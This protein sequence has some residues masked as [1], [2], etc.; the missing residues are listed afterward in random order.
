MFGGLRNHFRR[1]GH[2]HRAAGRWARAADAYG[3]HTRLHP[4]DL[5]DWIRLAE[6][7]LAAGR[8]GVAEDAYARAMAEAP[9][10]ADI[11]FQLAQSF[12][13]TGRE[14]EALTTFRHALQLSER[15]RPAL[16]TAAC[17]VPGSLPPAM[18]LYS[19]QDMISYFGAHPTMTGI[20]RV[21]AGIVRHLLSGKTGQVGFVLTDAEPGLTPGDFWLVDPDDLLAVI[22]AAEAGKADHPRLKSSIARCRK[23]ARPVRP[24][25]GHTLVVL[26]AFWALGNAPMRYL[27]AKRRGARVCVYLYDLIPV[28]HPQFCE[29]ELSLHFGVGLGQICA[30]ADGILTIS[31]DTAHRVRSLLADKGIAPIPVQA[32]PLAHTLQRLPPAIDSDPAG[33]N[34]FVAYVST[35]EGRKNH[36]YVVRVWQALMASGVAV[37]DLVF[38]GRPGWKVGP[39]MALLEQTDNLGGRVRILHDL[40]DAALA[41]IYRHAQFTVFTSL[42]EGWGLPIGESLSHGTPC[43]ASGTS[44]MPEV[45]G[46]L[47]DYID[48]DD[49]NDGVGVIGRLLAEPDRLLWRRQ[50]IAERFVPRTWDDVGSDLSKAVQA[51]ALD[52]PRPI[53]VPLL[54]TGQWVQPG[55]VGGDPDFSLEV[56]MRSPRGLLLAD[57]L[58]PQ[59][60]DRAWI[61]GK[62][63]QIRFRSDLPPLTLITLDLR[64][65]R[66]D[67]PVD[68][69]LSL[70]T[71]EA[72]V[73][74]VVSDLPLAEAGPDPISIAGRVERDGTVTLHLRIAKGSPDPT[75]PCA[76]LASLV[77]NV[78]RG[79]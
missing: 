8:A 77:Y 2:R 4:H 26:G 35:I 14:T 10:D 37:P 65:Y 38:V 53:A 7:A 40:T 46:D 18:D 60:D 32:I 55:V 42:V 61:V 30:M 73:E 51:I 21:Q 3:W 59:G 54:G 68:R 67:V 39:L 36:I 72:T 31:E 19:V 71:T 43:V 76:G 29:M 22:D 56:L 5:H 44:S 15:V 70:T 75:E 62:G 16:G 78:T 1:V 20:Q 33:E 58:Q 64:L 41:E 34:P 63:A 27:A 45:G 52:P 69:T 79:G 23:Q 49:V 66:A 74:V 6:C 50:Q 9:H 13:R 47:V 24:G 11:A 57:L 28:T 17:A 25:P 48:P 12:K